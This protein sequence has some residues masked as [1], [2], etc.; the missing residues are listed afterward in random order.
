MVDRNKVKR[1]IPNLLVEG[2]TSHPFTFCKYQTVRYYL[3]K[4][5][6]LWEKV[7][8]QITKILEEAEKQLFPKI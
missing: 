8:E 7:T 4:N 2:K 5:K 1:V 3:R 6:K